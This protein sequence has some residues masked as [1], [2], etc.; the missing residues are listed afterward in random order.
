[1]IINEE[2]K[3]TLERM[4][5]FL[6]TIYYEVYYSNLGADSNACYD[7]SCI[8]DDLSSLVSNAYVREEFDPMHYRPVENCDIQFRRL[9]RI[10]YAINTNWNSDKIYE[11]VKKIN[12]ESKDWLN[13]YKERLE[14]IE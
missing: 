14:E 7:I 4:V 10:K 9:G 6:E 11:R 8:K 13:T 2:E 12:K 3:A 1:M 5:E